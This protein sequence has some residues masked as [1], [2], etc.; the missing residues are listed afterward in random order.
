MRFRSALKPP[1]TLMAPD[2]ENEASAT[3]K[4]DR[5]LMSVRKPLFLAR[6]CR[7]AM[8]VENGPASSRSS[9]QGSIATTVPTRN[10]TPAAMALARTSASRTVQAD[11]RS[12]GSVSV[13]YVNP[14]KMAPNA[15]QMLCRKPRSVSFRPKSSAAR[16]TRNPM[17]MAT[18]ARPARTMGM[19]RVF[20][21]VDRPLRAAAR[22]TG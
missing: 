18:A 16:H 11:P 19:G 4:I 3:A 5:P 20:T 22:G 15:A 21:R 6:T 8:Y 13:Q 12:T 10:S 14:T 2:S 1:I 7:A 9:S 17:A